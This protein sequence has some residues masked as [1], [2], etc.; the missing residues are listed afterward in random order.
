MQ[1]DPVHTASRFLVGAL[2]ALAA[3]AATAAKPAPLPPGGVP[4][5]WKLVWADEF[6][7]PGLPDETKW[8]YDTSLNKQG[9]HN[10]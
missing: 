5:G 7:K 2:C 4:A 9:W 8:E 1:R 10:D 3:G 6:D